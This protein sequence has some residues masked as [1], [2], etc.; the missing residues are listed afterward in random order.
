VEVACDFGEALRAVE[1]HEVPF[2]VVV[3]DLTMPGT[4]GIALA[5]ELRRRGMR[6]PAL[7]LTGYGEGLTEQ[8]LRESGVSALVAKPVE[9]ASLVTRVHELFTASASPA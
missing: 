3:T 4:T 5:R 7:L 9:P 6:C 2:D 1:R 8:E